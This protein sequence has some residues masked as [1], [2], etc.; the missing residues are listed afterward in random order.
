[1]DGGS[2]SGS[3]ALP[4]PSR[5]DAVLLARIS[6]TR[7]GLRRF[8]KPTGQE[9][10]AARCGTSG[11]RSDA[12]CRLLE[13]ALWVAFRRASPASGGSTVCPDTLFAAPRCICLA[14]RATQAAWS[15]VAVGTRVTPRPPHRSVRAAFPHTA[16]ASGPTGAPLSRRIVCAPAPVTRLPGAAPGCVLCWL[17][18]PLATALGSTG[19][20]ADRSAFVRRLHSYYGGV[21]LPAPVHHRLRLL[22][23]PMRTA[24]VSR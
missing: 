21:R 24:G 6:H 1:M 12:P 10:R 3:A 4:P 22:A 20:A 11:K 8:K 5:H 7:C 9:L 13:P 17:A 14:E 18:F 19:S 16:P 2:G 23:F 15:V